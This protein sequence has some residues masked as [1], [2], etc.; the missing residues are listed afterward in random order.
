M[1]GSDVGDEDD[2]GNGDDGGE[3]KQNK[4]PAA[5][6]STLRTTSK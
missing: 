3:Y 5:V 4:C 1:T 2:G 6:L